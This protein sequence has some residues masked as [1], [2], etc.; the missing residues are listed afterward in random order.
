MIN[1]SVDSMTATCTLDPQLEVLF[2]LEKLRTEIGAEMGNLRT[3]I[4]AEMGDLRTELRFMS[5]ALSIAIIFVYIKLRSLE[6]DQKTMLNAIGVICS[7]LA[8]SVEGVYSPWQ[9]C[10]LKKRPNGTKDRENL[11]KSH[12]LF[13]RK[14]KKD[15]GERIIVKCLVTGIAGDDGQV[16]AAH[17]L[18]RRVKEMGFKRFGLDVSVARDCERNRIF[19]AKNIETAFDSSY[20][21]FLPS[22]EAHN[23]DGYHSFV[24]KVWSPALKGKL[25]FDGAPKGATI[26][27]FARESEKKPILV[28]CEKI[29]SRI[30]SV[31]AQL[32]YDNAVEMQWVNPE[33]EDRPVDFGTPL[34]DVPPTSI[35]ALKEIMAQACGEKENKATQREFFS[36]KSPLAPRNF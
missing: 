5:V 8:E 31:H 17:L 3:E 25:V 29:F 20:L 13:V 4:G 23:R 9:T 35:V 2:L 18:P 16:V 21:S 33:E 15:E 32:C 22:E 27:K 11:A 6:R 1:G 30:I 36:T 26:G 19:L 28:K 7:V 10:H 14:E 24:M 12:G 34:K